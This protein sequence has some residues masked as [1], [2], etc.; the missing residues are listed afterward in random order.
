M[1]DADEVILMSQ[2]GVVL[3]TSAAEISMVGRN[4]QGVR[5]MKLDEKDKVVTLARV[6]SA[7]P[8]SEEKEE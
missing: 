1:K 6:V 8:H 5:L 4:T 2:N 7:V 3:R